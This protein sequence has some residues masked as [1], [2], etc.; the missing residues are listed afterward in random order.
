M[1]L[2]LLLRFR[3]PQIATAVRVFKDITC[4]LLLTW[5]HFSPHVPPHFLSP[6]PEGQ[7]EEHTREHGENFHSSAIFPLLLPDGPSVRTEICFLLLLP[8]VRGRQLATFQ[9]QQPR[10]RRRRRPRRRW[11]CHSLVG[12]PENFLHLSRAPRIPSA[13]FSSATIFAFCQINF[14]SSP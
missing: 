2:L 3:Q 4:L 5:P 7:S 10:P 6:P 11:D 8:S 14:F 13:H 12:F 1:L 9:I